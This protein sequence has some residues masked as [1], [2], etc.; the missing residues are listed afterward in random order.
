MDNIGAWWR[1]LASSEHNILVDP[2]HQEYSN[3]CEQRNDGLKREVKAGEYQCFDWIN[4]L[5]A[6]IE[7]LAFELF[8][9]LF[10]IGVQLIIGAVVVAAFD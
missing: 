1:P 8:V 10:L 3:G 5:I 2:V 4:V 6:N 9:E 7:W